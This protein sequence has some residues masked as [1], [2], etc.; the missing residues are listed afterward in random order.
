MAQ[1]PQRTPGSQAR[2]VALEAVEDSAIVRRPWPTPVPDPGWAWRPGVSGVFGGRDASRTDDAERVE[3]AG[4]GS[5]EEAFGSDSSGSSLPDRRET[6]VPRATQVAGAPTRTLSRQV[7][8]QTG[9]SPAATDPRSEPAPECSTEGS[10]AACDGPA[11][12]A[13]DNRRFQRCPATSKA[14]A[15]ST[16]AVPQ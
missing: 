10:S 8:R 15:D 5:G 2:L 1:M 13:R 11:Q 16:V 6:P 14:P 12:A 4:A 3:P 9:Q 7:N